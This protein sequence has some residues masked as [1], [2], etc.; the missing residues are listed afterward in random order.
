[1]CLDGTTRAVERQDV[2]NR[3]NAP[4][5]LDSV[6]LICTNGL[7]VGTNFAGAHTVIGY[8]C[9]GKPQN[10]IEA[11]ASC[12]RVG[13]AKQSTIYRLIRAEGWERATFDCA[14]GTTAD[15]KTVLSR[16]LAFQL[17]DNEIA[18]MPSFPL[19]EVIEQQNEI[20]E[21]PA[22]QPLIAQPMKQPPERAVKYRKKKGMHVSC[23]TDGR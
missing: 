22:M 18:V 13:R 14:N 19:P 20:I 23:E 16:L 9:H 11:A 3:F 1:M 4:S 5:S 17:P 21:F 12:I 7:G 10:N 15:L 6:A 2:I 8:D